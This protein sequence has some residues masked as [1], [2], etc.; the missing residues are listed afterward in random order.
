MQIVEELARLTPS[1]DVAL[2]IGVFDGVHLGHR[3]LLDRVMDTALELEALSGVV[4][5]YPHPRQVVFQEEAV[6]YLSTLEE[7]VEIIKS[8]GIE[9]IATLSFTPKL[10]RLGAREFISLIQEHLRMRELVVGPDFALGRGREGDLDTLATLGDEQGF[11]VR[12]VPPLE[13]DGMVVSS[14]AIRR[15]LSEGDVMQ[16]ARLLGRRV[17]IGGRVTAGARR[18]KG[19]G[20]PT[21]NLEVQPDLALPGNGVYVTRAY[22]GSSM[23][24]S[25]TN[26][27][28]NPTFGGRRR[29][30]EVHL[31]D[32][33]GDVYGQTIRIELL[34]RLREE[35][36]FTTVEELIAQMHRDVADTRRILEQSTA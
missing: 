2:T 11:G 12:V 10:A 6:S 23:H 29:T 21:A 8:L 27:G 13:M 7:R 36:R 33:D 25:V 30:V 9:L 15:A 28:F 22:L 5:F 16:A 35:K 32:F 31:L 4:T 34:R 14:T 18:G 17:S 24:P 26:I 3:H 1:R 20:F 19:L